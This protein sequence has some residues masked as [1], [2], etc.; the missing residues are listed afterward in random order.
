MLAK[1]LKLAFRH[2]NKD[3]LYFFINIFGLA[4]SIV[5]SLFLLI[6]VQDELSYDNHYQK[7]DKIYRIT[8][9]FLYDESHFARCA[10]AFAPLMNEYFPEI[11]EIVRLNH[12]TKIVNI[13]DNKFKVDNFF[14][15]D[16]NFFNVF[17]FEF[18]KGSS[19]K[20]LTE[21]NSVV[22]SENIANKLFGNKNPLN[23]SILI[24]DQEGN[25][26]YKVTGVIS[27]SKR[28]S[29]FHID[30]LASFNSQN[31]DFS[32]AWFRLGNFYTYLLLKDN[33]DY[34]SIEEKV[35]DFLINKMDKDR[36][37]VV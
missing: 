21:P 2:I 13:K 25:H 3:K 30:I 19:D 15:A 32:N 33:C 29:H 26:V 4:I 7:K 23:E 10:P 8:Q 28:N 35:P 16:S 20:A 11:E 6:Y 14:Y 37:S 24:L 1:N 5:F 12:Q 31:A 34:K 36:K 18:Q 27:N 22:L 9:K 17:D